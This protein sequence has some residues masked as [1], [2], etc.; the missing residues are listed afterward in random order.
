[1]ENNKE[2]LQKT[3]NGIPY[4]SSILLLGVYLGEMSTYVFLGTCLRIVI[5]VLLVV[6][7]DGKKWLMVTGK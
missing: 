6:L 2:V 1:M 7:R 3:K 4:D 5:V